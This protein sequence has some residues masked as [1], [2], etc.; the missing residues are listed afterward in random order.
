MF[1]INKIKKNEKQETNLTKNQQKNAK[2][3]QKNA[4]IQKIEKK[5]CFLAKTRKN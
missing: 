3:R 1:L 4:K 2:N 5:G